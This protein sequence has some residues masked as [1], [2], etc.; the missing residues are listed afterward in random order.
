MQINDQSI[1]Q[2]RALYY[3]FFAK[4]VSFNAQA[5]KYA[6]IADLLKIFIANPLDED[7]DAAFRSIDSSLRAKGGCE[8]LKQEYDE[9]F[10]S[11]ESSFIPMSASYY[12]EGRDDGPKRVKAAGLVFRSKFRKNDSVCN[13]SEDQV[14]F[15]FQFMSRL[16]EAGVAGDEESLALAKEVFAEILNDFIDEFTALL[17]QH[18]KSFFYQNTAIVLKT[19]IA[20]E[21]LFL[22]VEASHK[23]ASEERA[24]AVIQKDRKPLTQRVRRNLDEIVL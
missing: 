20:F 3:T 6:K 4:I 21:R 24:S 15:L 18:E 10:V 9:V 8:A 22:H 5:D 19:F 12:D 23:I 2:A 1:H 13:D 11:P 16:I 17:L 14:L 7:S